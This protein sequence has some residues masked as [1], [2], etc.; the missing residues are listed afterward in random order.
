MG[1]ILAAVGAIARV[2]IAMRRAQL[3]GEV[4]R[5]ELNRLLRVPVASVADVDPTL[6][7]IDRAEQKILPGGGVPTY[8]RRAAD[9][10][11]RGAVAAAL[12]N[13][14]PWIVVVEGPS[15]VGK[16]RSLFQ[17]L[18]ECAGTRPLELVAPVNGDALRL[19]L[20]PGRGLRAPS[21]ARRC[22]GWMTL[23]RFSTA[24]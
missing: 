1:V 16:S 21:A 15:K 7:G 23:S 8:V 19:L 9:G 10:E 12:D 18:C 17:A 5:A 24:A 2:M 3:E 4:E 14:A 11:L 6:I 22:C 13:S 20:T